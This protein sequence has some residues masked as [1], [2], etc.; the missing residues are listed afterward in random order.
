MRN[1]FYFDLR[2]FTYYVTCEFAIFFFLPELH[3]F[4][5]SATYNNDGNG[6]GDDDDDTIRMWKCGINEDRMKTIRINV[7]ELILGGLEE[8]KR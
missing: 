1:L 7:T 6:D 4:S 5:A 8:K 3:K 2:R